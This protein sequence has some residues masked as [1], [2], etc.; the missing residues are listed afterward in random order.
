MRRRG[1]YVLMAAV[2]LALAGAS[3]WVWLSED[4]GKKGD[5]AT[6]VSRKKVSRPKKSG[7]VNAPRGKTKKA[8]TTRHVVSAQKPWFDIGEAEKELNEEQRRL[9]EEIRLALRDDDFRKLMRLVHKLQSSDEWPDGIPKQ[10]KM[11]ALKA[12]GWYGGKCLTEMVGFL[13][14]LD[15]EIVDTA[16]SYWD[17]AIAELDHDVDRD[18]EPGIASNIKSAAKVVTSA[19][20]MESILS[21]IQSSLRHSVAVDTIKDILANGNRVAAERI[22]EIIENLTGS[23]EIKTA[24]QLDEWL[25]SNPDDPDD[26]FMYGGK[27]DA[28][29][30][31]ED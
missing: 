24:E 11:A 1:K 23:S 18:G 6:L 19:E 15:R 28:A 30:L 3:A 5:S 2:A 25:K 17:D 13:A 4:V 29:D 9:L 22:P 10:I 31:D 8:K 26:D 7:R 21:E 14:D 12:L 16:T 27:E 20:A